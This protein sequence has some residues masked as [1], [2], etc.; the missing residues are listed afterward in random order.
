M[1]KILRQAI[2][3]QTHLNRAGVKTP[4]MQ[5]RLNW[6]AGMFFIFVKRKSYD[7]TLFLVNAYLNIF[8]GI[9]IMIHELSHDKLLAHL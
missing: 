8:L 6:L 5:A 7:F 3:R 2:L 4:D 1:R 9:I